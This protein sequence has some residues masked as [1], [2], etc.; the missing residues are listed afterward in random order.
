MKMGEHTSK[1]DTL[2]SRLLDLTLRNNL[3]NYKPSPA[4]SIEIN[5]ELTA[6]AVY[7]T[8]VISERG[9]KFYPTSKKIDTPIYEKKFWKYPI[10]TKS[11]KKQENI[12][13]KTP[14]D[15]IS[16]RKRLYTLANKSRTVFEEQGY[17]VLYLALGFI[18]WSE[19][20][21]PKKH[22]KAP[23]LLIPVELTR[24]KVKDNY[25]L[26]WTGDEPITS[27]SLSAKLAEQGINLP[28][29]PM[30]ETTKDFNEYITAVETTIHEKGWKYCQD[31]ALDLF[32]FHK[33]VM[34]KDLDSQSW[35]EKYAPETHP[36]IAG[37]FHPETPPT[38]DTNDTFPENEIDRRLP[39]EKSYNIMDADASQIAVIEEVKSG[40]NLV[41]EGPPGTGKSQTVANMIAEMLVCGK[42]VL[43][44]SEKMA[45]LEVVKRRL[46]TAGLSRFC[47][48][49]HS[50]KA[51]KREVIHDIERSIQ[52]SG[53]TTTPKNN[54]HLQIN[55]LREEL[56]GYCRELATPI[57]AC[58]F[59]PYDL[60][61]ICE[62]Y[63]YEFEDNPTGPRRKIQR[64][65]IHTAKEI[66]PEQYK[67][68][69]TALQ[70]IE[71]LLPSLMPNGRF[72]S[73]HPWAK[74][75][76]GRI[77]PQ[78]C[79]EIQELVKNYYIAIEK[80]FSTIQ[81]LSEFTGVPIPQKVTEVSQMI[82]SCHLLTRDYSID[83]NTLINP[84]WSKETE[85]TRL[86]TGMQKLAE[87][88][89]R[90]LT[91]FTPEIL[92]R[93]PN[94]L[95]AAFREAS[96]K[97]AI[98]KI[99]SST[100]KEIKAEIASYYRNGIP[101]D[102]QILTDLLDVRDYLTE[103][104]VLAQ[105]EKLYASTF[106][107]VWN[108]E[109]TEPTKLK[110]YAEWIFAILLMINEGRAT[111]RTL[112]LLI[113]GSITETT[114]NSLCTDVETAEIAF[115]DSQMKLMSR[116]GMDKIKDSTFTELHNRCNLWASSIDDIVLWSKF[117]SYT[118]ALSKTVA[119]PLLEPLFADKVAP[120]ELVPI[121]LMGYADSLL[122]E[123]IFERPLLAH[124]S[125]KSHEQKIATFSAYDR[126][127]IVENRQRIAKI[128]DEKIPE[129]CI[130][131]TQDAKMSILTG[132]FNRKR[133]HMSI[134]ML[135]SKTGCLIQK[136]KP[137]FMMS[138]LS[139]AQYLDP[140]S[141]QFDVIIF[142]EASQIRPEDALGALM[143]G[144]QL[145]VMGDSHQLPP[146][147]F[148]DQIA[149]TNDTDETEVSASIADMESLLNVCKQFYEI[150]RLRW[151]YRSR[152]ESLIAVS[153]QEFYDG[154]LIV[155]PSPM[156]ETP[157]LGLS[158]IHLPDT[159]YERGKTGINR[160][161]ARAVAKAVIEYY[162][163]FPDKTLGVATFSTRQQEIIQH[164][165]E[166]LLREKP[167][168]EPKMRPENGENFFV[169]NLETIQGDERDTILISIG[170]G[171]DENHKL[172]QNFGPLNHEGGERRLNV[173]ITR[174]RERCVVFANF[175]GS[176]LKIEPG[177]TV[178]IS[179]L[180]TFMTYAADRTFRLNEMKNGH[181]NGTGLFGET[182]ARLL[183]DNGYT[184]SKNVGCSGFQI[185]IAVENPI[186]PGMYLIGILCDSPN[187]WSS[188]V[189][190]D[191]DRLRTQVLEGLGWNLI[192][193][194]ATE[195]YQHP[196]S[197]AKTL[198]DAIDAVKKAEKKKTDKTKQVQNT[199]TKKSK[200][201][202][203]IT[204]TSDEKNIDSIQL[205]PYIFYE[206]ESL[207]MYHQFKSVP[208]SVLSTT[209]MQIVAIEGPISTSILTERLKKISHVPRMT[210][211]MRDR[212]ISIVIE[213]IAK[214][215]LYTD[216]EGFL[217]VPEC[218]IIPRKR[219]AKW[220]PMDIAIAEIEEAAIFVLKKQCLKL[221]NELI[222]QTAV[223]LGLKETR[224]TKNRIGI[225]ID[226]AV[227][228]GKIF[229]DGR[230][231]K[232]SK[233]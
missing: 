150:K 51:K 168:I 41:V 147:T 121:F 90:I 35:D 50:H 63:R 197:C 70:D 135:M 180:A 127:A 73:Q 109:E 1:L 169:K 98:A 76:P 182:I 200:K 223:S 190:R 111:S 61:G 56:D 11:S 181:E 232:F 4:R 120:G 44:V 105:D 191:R 186:K 74:S 170:Y 231:Y 57:G 104:D 33:F 89:T 43:F 156:H 178:G 66:T 7:H 172:S 101:Q 55:S 217:A 132:E 177:T 131:K 42:T 165:V 124:F 116:I 193:I 198:L 99:F 151:H 123:A 195:W 143:R 145:V 215:M 206:D 26:K 118:E 228:D 163:K 87:H 38:T 227:A 62:Q 77:L 208:D 134:R 75:I 86:I 148:F 46:E 141:I 152:H 5:E 214:K 222:Q 10:F 72:L 136:I 52:Y 225:A 175:R 23:L 9:M 158:F 93:N 96:G 37:L 211:V 110:K 100:Y 112:D 159:V 59:T 185:D 224:Q 162:Q 82:E 122:R 3:L 97:G 183:E 91:S 15:E 84:I 12:I 21:H 94:R 216:N 157:D 27:L 115:N 213:K 78:D 125:Q 129:F 30:P 58:A 102:S 18:N 142:D 160:G 166:I 199:G 53:C 88:R 188:Q 25:I 204:E 205:E 201:N 32:N 67:D 95:Y 219:P 155:F 154:N 203:N 187:Y 212:I 2:R 103:R 146:T 196:K 36:L 81:K 171:F 79:D 133:G 128:L 29:F 130:G 69:I 233:K 28:D 65:R 119:A 179:A 113:T 210:A 108:G 49:L 220:S 54:I 92:A 140:R 192:H 16:L 161:E 8:L 221:R 176:D 218:V 229:F 24:Q 114:V 126:S 107:P 106:A 139:V 17:S 85:V 40:K 117:L 83:T 13:L 230:L 137:C 47:L 14:Y 184:V 6:A 60:F 31:I 173:L 20:E 71:A 167:E 48:E 22:Y 149:S 39:S 189:A 45:A 153:N 68:A 80:Y 226:I 138:P 34:F 144:H 202:S 174:A 207:G 64:I 209:I 19:A 194:W 164:E